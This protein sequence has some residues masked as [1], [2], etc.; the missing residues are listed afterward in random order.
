MN[1]FAPCPR[2]LE[3]L[4]AD[5]LAALGATDPKAVPGGVQFAGDWALCYRAN[6]ESRIAT[7]V[8]WQIT[9]GR[10]RSE[11]L[12]RI[13]LWPIVNRG[14]EAG[15]G[16]PEDIV[17]DSELTRVDGRHVKVVAWY[18]NEWGFSN[19][20]VDTLTLLAA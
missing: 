4:L 2:G 8:L 9:M 19:R 17:F 11:A 18:D 16:R 15:F 10:Y 6:L 14:G 3:P 13:Q 12:P 7:R 20:V 1:F 5:E